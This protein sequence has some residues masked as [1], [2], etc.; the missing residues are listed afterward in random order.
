MTRYQTVKELRELL[1]KLPDDMVILK[2]SGDH[3]YSPARL[4]V[5]D[6]HEEW[7]GRAGQHFFTSDDAGKTNA[8][9]VVVV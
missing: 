9:A 6:V 2:E 7:H 4:D 8:K 5:G 1:A 3:A